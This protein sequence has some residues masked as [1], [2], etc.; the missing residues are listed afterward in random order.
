MN[1]FSITEKIE[2]LKK[3]KNFLVLAHNYQTLEV[4]KA[5]DFVGDSFELCKKAQS[6]KKENIAFCGVNFMAETA[7]LLNPDKNVFISEK[8]AY[9]TMAQMLSE[10]ELVSIK[11]KHP[12]V[13]VVCYINSTVGVKAL[14]D[15]VCTS[16][17]AVKIVRK[18]GAKQII[19]VP[20]KNLG[21]YVAGILKDI[22][23][24]T[25]N[26]FC[27]V[28]HEIYPEDIQ[29]EKKRHPAA[30][31]LCHPEC[32]KELLSNCDFVGSTSQIID[33]VSKSEKK[34]FI[35]STEEGLLDRLRND[36]PEKLI[37]SASLPR[38]CYGMKKTD[39]QS[40]LALL[41]N[42]AE[43]LKIPLQI[44]E[45]ARKSVQRMMELSQ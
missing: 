22:H 42:P 39:L 7:S 15:V 10:E 27:Y 38:V 4:Q 26:A 28:H 3:E 6:S 11:E 37:F 36:Y 12:R 34:E 5:A 8:N 43:P 9:C 31:S 19:F 44:A 1:E 24:F 2:N 40:L 25:L 33:Y 21:S 23:V 20:D 29:K 32:Q 14:S 17:N 41:E 45:K 35:V 16:S 30:L 13:P 18:L